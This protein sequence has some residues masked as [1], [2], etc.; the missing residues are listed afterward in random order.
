MSDNKVTLKEMG[1]KYLKEVMAD[2]N[3]IDDTYKRNHLKLLTVQVI[4]DMEAGRP[5]VKEGREAFDTSVPKENNTAQETAKKAKKAAEKVL[6]EE[7]ATEEIA[8]VVENIEEEIAEV[9]AQQDEIA[10]SNLGTDE[11]EIQQDAPIEEVVESNDPEDLTVEVEGEVYDISAFYHALAYVPG[12]EAKKE[13]A[14]YL[15]FYSEPEEGEE[16]GYADLVAEAFSSNLIVEEGKTI[17]EF[18]NE[19]NYEAFLDYFKAC[20]QG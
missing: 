5:S 16:K 4:N 12:G 19:N 13:I 9:A 6:A 20:L 1:I 17:Y 2:I 18:L 10:E 7:P 3:S 11:A 15:A 8:Q 14:M